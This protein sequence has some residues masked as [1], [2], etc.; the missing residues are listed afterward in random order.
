M[1]S[2]AGGAIKEEE[3]EARG[4]IRC[5]QRAAK[6]YHKSTKTNPSRKPSR[7]IGLTVPSRCGDG[8]VV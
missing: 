7:T 8:P 5:R 4:D 1:A 6:H 2:G 3:E